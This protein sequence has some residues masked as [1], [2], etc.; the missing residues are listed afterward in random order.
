MYKPPTLSEDLLESVHVEAGT[1][2]EMYASAVSCL[3]SRLDAIE[4]AGMLCLGRGFSDRGMVLRG[5]LS[6]FFLSQGALGGERSGGVCG[7]A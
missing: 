3:E 5:A 1:P 2:A 7:G 4:R 6:S